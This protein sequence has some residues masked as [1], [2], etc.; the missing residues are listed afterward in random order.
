ME[1]L[2]VG[3]LTLENLASTTSLKS[4]A[5]GYIL[6]CR[7]EGKSASTIAIY[8]T[9]LNKFIWFCERNN[10]PDQPQ[11]FTT[12]HVREFLWYLASEPNRWG[13]NVPSAKKP[14][15]QTT[16]NDYYRAL[17][18]FFSWLLREGL[19]VDSPLNHLKTPKVERKVVQA[20][21]PGEVDK[22]LATC[23]TKAPMD[24]RNRAILMVLLDCGLRADEAAKLNLSDVDLETG[25]IVVRRGKGGKGRVVHIGTKTAKVLWRYV[26]LSRKGSSGRLFLGRSGE[27]LNRGGLQTLIVRLGVKAGVKVYPHKLRHTFATSYLRNGGD[28]FSLKYLLGHSSLAMVDRYLQSLNAEDAANAHKRFSPMDNMR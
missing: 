14:A 12:S 17:H 8:G 20:L 13:A 28:I 25:A 19:I 15:S 1:K 5:K 18:S 11:K 26:T 2:A 27:P 10:Y 7:C 23:A 16:V 24:V 21:T 6:N 9:V 22:L 4:L 3:D